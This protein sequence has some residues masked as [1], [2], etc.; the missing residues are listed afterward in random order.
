MLFLIFFSKSFVLDHYESIGKNT[1]QIAIFFSGFCCTWGRTLRTFFFIASALL[2]L[3]RKIPMFINLNFMVTSDG[4]ILEYNVKNIYPWL[5]RVFSFVLLERAE[6][7]RTG[8]T[9]A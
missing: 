7:L 5:K 2:P 3:F 4:Q 9:A 6:P 1:I 8:G